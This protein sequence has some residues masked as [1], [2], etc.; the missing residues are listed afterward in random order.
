MKYF[1][2]IGNFQ[3]IPLSIFLLSNTYFKNN[4]SYIECNDIYKMTENEL[5]NMYTNILPKIDLIILQPIDE[6]L[7]N[8]ILNSVNTNCIK[9]LIPLMYFDYYHPFYKILNNKYHDIHLVDLY[10][11]NNQEYHNNDIQFYINKYYDKIYNINLLDKNYFINKLLKYVND[12]RLNELKY[13]NYSTNDT[14]IINSSSIIINNYNKFLLFYTPNH[15]SKYMFQSIVNNIFI[16]MGIPLEDYSDDIDPYKNLLLPIYSCVANNVSF[17]IAPYTKLIDK[18][19]E[20]YIEEY[21]STDISI[22]SNFI[23][24]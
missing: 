3:I 6:E 8:L 24:E 18:N 2:I 4:Y 7:N 21:K 17:E 23:L 11:K 1:T 22:L 12:L 15:P 10:I 5:D 13:K 19:I 20:K 9:I 14:N 16:I